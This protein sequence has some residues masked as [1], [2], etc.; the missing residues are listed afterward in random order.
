M[1]VKLQ[2]NNCLIDLLCFQNISLPTL[3]EIEKKRKDINKYKQ[4]TYSDREISKI[5]KEKQ[6]FR[7]VPVNY[8]VAK[9]ELWKDIVRK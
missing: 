3:D 9:Q 5:V 4:H 8:A 2:I 6:R 1:Y 7:K